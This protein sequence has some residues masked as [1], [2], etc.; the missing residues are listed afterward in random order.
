MKNGDLWPFIV[1]LPMKNGGSFDSLALT[2]TKR[3]GR[4][5]QN[6]CPESNGCSEVGVLFPSSKRSLAINHHKSKK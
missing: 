5:P 6:G 2:F 3:P 1:D 4:Q